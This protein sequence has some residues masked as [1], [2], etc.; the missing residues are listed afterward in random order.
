MIIYA[1]SLVFWKS[2]L[3]LCHWTALFQNTFKSVL[4]WCLSSVSFTIIKMRS[5]SKDYL[6]FTTFRQGGKIELTFALLCCKGRKLGTYSIKRVAASIHLPIAWLFEPGKRPDNRAVYCLDCSFLPYSASTRYSFHTWVEWGAAFWRW[7]PSP[8]SIS[9]ELGYLA[10]PTNFL[11][12]RKNQTAKRVSNPSSLDPEST[13]CPLRHT[14]WAL[15]ENMG[16][17]KFQPRVDT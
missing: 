16:G 4:S 12:K 3:K 5:L 14:G 6:Y 2:L 9:R 15:G 10:G 8:M 17:I 1:K 11:A 7:R 13:L